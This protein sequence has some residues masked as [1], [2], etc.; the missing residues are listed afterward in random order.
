MSQGF[1]TDNLSQ[2]TSRQD[3]G[4]LSLI[5]YTLKCLLYKDCRAFV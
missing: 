4:Q 5:P 2:K 3:A 1:E